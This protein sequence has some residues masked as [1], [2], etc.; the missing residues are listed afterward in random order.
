MSDGMWEAAGCVAVSAE[1]R[2]RGLGRISNSLGTGN[3]SSIT[4]SITPRARPSEPLQLALWRRMQDYFYYTNGRENILRSSSLVIFLHFPELGSIRQFWNLLHNEGSVMDRRIQTQVQRILLY[5]LPKLTNHYYSHPV[6]S[7]SSAKGNCQVKFSLP[8]CTSDKLSLCSS[9]R[10]L[11]CSC[12]TARQRGKS[13]GLWADSRREYCLAIT[14]HSRSI[15]G[16]R[17]GPSCP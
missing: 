1:G 16:R 2:N 8:R 10:N 17:I 9:A 6:S 13:L 7:S 3:A 12:I 4:M 14:I 15:A 5:S 11:P